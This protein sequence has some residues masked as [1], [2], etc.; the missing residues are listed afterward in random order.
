MPP[1]T[2]VEGVF[3]LCGTIN[4]LKDYIPS[5]AS[6]MEPIHALKRKDVPFV[7]TGTQQKTFYRVK[8]LISNSPNLRYYDSE[9]Q[10]TVQCDASLS[11]LGAVLLQ[12]GVPIAYASR[13]LRDAETRYSP[14]EKELLAIAWSLE[15]FHQYTYARHLLKNSINTHM[16]VMYMYSQITNLL[17]QILR[18]PL[19]E[20]STHLQRMVMRLQTYDINVTWLAG[21]KQ[22]LG[23]TLSRAYIPADENDNLQDDLSTIYSLHTEYLCLAREDSRN[24]EVHC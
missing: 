23:D 20:V 3:R 6:V 15:K 2:D 17:K 1:P 5:L 22:V 14:I 18:K 4:F 19:H 9:K 16:R 11:G 10:L 12:E 24:T 7:W 13:V 21:K 8:E